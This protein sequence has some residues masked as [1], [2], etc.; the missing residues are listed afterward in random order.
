MPFFAVIPARQGGLGAATPLRGYRYI[1][2]LGSIAQRHVH[3]PRPFAR[4]RG[5][6]LADRCEMKV[7]ARRKVLR[8][9]VRG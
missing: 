7:T 9:A 1:A 5:I 3:A 4:K 6:A 2:K 8:K